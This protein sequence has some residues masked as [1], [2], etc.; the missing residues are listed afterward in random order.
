[1]QHVASCKFGFSRYLNSPAYTVKSRGL[2]N[3]C[4]VIHR[5]IAVPAPLK[6]RLGF[7]KRESVTVKWPERSYM[8]MNCCLNNDPH[9]LYLSLWQQPVT[10]CPTNLS[11]PSASVRTLIWSRFKKIGDTCQKSHSNCGVGVRVAF[12]PSK[13]TMTVRICYSAQKPK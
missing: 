8:N 9:L 7:G 5:W 1:M 2:W 12:L 3:I 6:K 11:K 10:N 4:R 13:Q